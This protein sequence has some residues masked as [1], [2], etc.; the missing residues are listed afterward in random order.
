LDPIA[1]AEILS[2]FAEFRSAGG[3]ILFS[4]H[5]MA[6]AETLCD[7]VVMLASGRTVF[8]GSLTEASGRA[9]HGAVVVTSDQAGLLAAARSVDGEARPV[10]G[11]IGEATRWRVVLPAHVPH[12]AL[13]RALAEHA[14]PIF[15]FEPIK[16]D[17]EGAFW[18]LASPAKPIETMARS[19]AA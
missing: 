1:Q 19:R 15:T 16:E 13:M 9:P 12:P 11:A 8:E 6:A 2:L 5:S 7:R 3:A 14:V 4:T 10:A 18:D 17:L